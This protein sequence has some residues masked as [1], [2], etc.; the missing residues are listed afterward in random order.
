M[1]LLTRCRVLLA[2]DGLVLAELANAAPSSIGAMR[3]VRLEND[4]GKV[5]AWFPWAMVDSGELR[6]AAASAGLRVVAS[7]RSAGRL[8]V[9]LA[10]TRTSTP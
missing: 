2:P 3:R 8:F 4:A 9:A 1:R 6:R 10:R 7:W 5:S